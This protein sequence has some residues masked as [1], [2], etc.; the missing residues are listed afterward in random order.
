MGFKTIRLAVKGIGMLASKIYSESTPFQTWEDF[1]DENNGGDDRID[2]RTISGTLLGS[3]PLGIQNTKFRKLDFEVDEYG[4]KSIRFEL[5]SKPAFPLE[6]F[7]VIRIRVDGVD[8]FGGY[9][10]KYPR[11]GSSSKQ[12]LEFQGLGFRERLKKVTIRPAI[13]KHFYTIKSITKSGLNIE[14]KLNTN[15]HPI[16]NVGDIF[17]IRKA[18]NS[19]NNGKYTVSSIE[20]DTLIALRPDGLDQEIAQGTVTVL[21]SQWTNATT[22]VSDIL[23]QII[24]EYLPEVKGIIASTG[25]VTTSSSVP[26]GGGIDLE[27]ISI[28]KAFDFIRNMLGGEW[29]LVVEPDGR[30][31]LNPK[32]TAIIEKIFSSYD[33]QIFDFEENLDSIV[34]IV[35]VNRK[36]EKSAD[37]TTPMTLGALRTNQTSIAKYG[38][39]EEP[40]DVPA[41]FTDEIC[42]SLALAKIN[43]KS[44]PK[45]EGSTKKGKWKY[46][47]FGNYSIVTEEGYYK[48]VLHEMDSLEGF[49]VPSG[50]SASIS[51]SIFITGAGSLKLAFGNSANGKDVSCPLD[52]R[53]AGLKEIFL[54]VYGNKIGTYIRFG[55][56]KDTFKENLFK[57]TI[58]QT[59][60]PSLIVLPVDNL[61]IDHIKEMGFIIDNPQDGTEV[62]IDEVAINSYTS[63]H[64]TQPL[65]LVKYHYNQFNKFCELNFGIVTSKQENWLAGLNAKIESQSMA[66]KER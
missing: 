10:F 53:V 40:I 38:P 6:R 27:G 43:A 29:N 52:K 5:N 1:I 31:T 64:K 22:P 56:G 26:L 15:V 4:S 17:Y 35:E 19:R 50:I 48:E 42:D 8:T 65:K 3:I 54:Y 47:K 30:I 62:Y 57:I 20:D 28:E 25:G 66:M 51:S 34:N 2:F 59:T 39:M 44:E 33:G 9:I 18:L 16:I 32:S 45:E 7:T 41:Y 13:D 37:G 24:I 36:K 63:L 23:K 21:P 49:V 11:Q 58:N 46:W 14:I 60:N 61:P 55:I 12:K